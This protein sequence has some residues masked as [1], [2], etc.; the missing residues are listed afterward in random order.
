MSFCKKCGNEL[1][2]GVKFCN[3]CGEPVAS[4][5]K[6]NSQKND[7]L[8]KIKPRCCSKCGNELK[9]G[10]K[11]CNKCGEAITNISKENDAKTEVAKVNVAKPN[12]AKIDVAKPNVAKV[13]VAK[14][15]VVKAD[16]AKPNVAKEVSQKNNSLEKIK[17]KCCAKCGNEFKKEVKFCD[18][19]GEPVINDSAKKDV[20]ESINLLV[21]YNEK[22]K[23]KEDKKVSETIRTAKKAIN[24]HRILSYIDWVAT[25]GVTI[26]IG[27]CIYIR[28]NDILYYLLVC[29]GCLAVPLAITLILDLIA[30]YRRRSA[31]KE[32]ICPMCLSKGHLNN[33]GHCTKC[34][35]N[36]K[37]I[38]SDSRIRATHLLLFLAYITLL[39]FLS[40]IILNEY[41]LVSFLEYVPGFIKNY[42]IQIGVYLLFLPIVLKVYMYPHRLAQKTEHV[43]TKEI[44][45]ILIVNIFIPFAWN[46]IV[47]AILL[48][49]SSTG[50]NQSVLLKQ[51]K[52]N[53]DEMVEKIIAAQNGNAAQNS[54]VA[55]NGN[56]VQNSNVTQNSNAVQNSSVMQNNNAVQNNNAMPASEPRVYDKL[57]E[58]KSLLDAGILTEEEFNEK[59]KQLLEKL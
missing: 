58:L 47:W 39:I 59:K 17:P 19:C 29:L 12:V 4:I 46:I 9:E 3:K 50:N 24:A 2:E 23:G 32:D 25:M 45:V 56:A 40:Y 30:G 1:K 53:S 18:K 41:G 33:K 37:H 44:F 52:I 21:S 26:F 15:N 48:F 43:A 6:E 31:I 13:E 7:T 28:D 34:N 20:D 22:R 35:K 8:E 54:N 38:I 55:Q 14:P 27:W 36:A 57:I 11:F 51:N 5:S 16:N 10:V 49:W 42:A